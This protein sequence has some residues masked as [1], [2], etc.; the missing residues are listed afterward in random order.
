MIRFTEISRQDFD[1]R[2]GWIAAS[3]TYDTNKWERVFRLDLAITQEQE[4]EIRDW[5]IYNLDHTEWSLHVSLS[6]K[7]MYMKTRGSDTAFA[8]KM[9]WC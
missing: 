9:R 8:F 1:R 6:G 3:I 4:D 5:C 2:Q 7:C